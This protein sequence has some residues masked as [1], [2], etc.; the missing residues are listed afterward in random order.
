MSYLNRIFLCTLLV[1]FSLILKLSHNLGADITPLLVAAKNG[2]RTFK[3]GMALEASFLERIGV[4]M[5]ITSLSDGAGGAWGNFVT[6]R[7]T[8]QLLRYMA[9]RPDFKAFHDA[10]PILGMDGTLAHSVAPDSSTRGKVYAKTGTFFQGDL[11]NDRIILKVKALAGYMTALSGRKLAFALYVNN[12]ATNDFND[13]S[14]VGND[15]GK[16]AEIIYMA[17]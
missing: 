8:V 11:L 4:N 10:L 13:I 3:E 1:C 17:E 14:Q 12:V 5:K 9:T 6:P 2:R 16:L 15:L 7:T